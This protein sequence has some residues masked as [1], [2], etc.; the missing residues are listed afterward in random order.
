VIHVFVESNWI[1]DVCVPTFRRSP[2]AVA[3]LDHAAR[4]DVQIHIPH[5]C[6]REAKAV[7]LRKHQPKEHS[8]LQQ[9]RKW[10]KDQQ[11]IDESASATVNSF[12]QIFSNTVTT[13]LTRLDQ[14]LTEIE[15]ARGVDVFAL[16]EQM[17]ERSIELRTEVPDPPLKPF[18]EAILAAV[19]VR[20]T[21]LAPDARRA[22]CT[23]D[24]D[25]SP[26]VRGSVRKHLKAIYDAAQI[27]VRT[28]FD[29][30]GI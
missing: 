16:D 17:L 14:R 7:I 23:L 22:F 18:D 25:L 15:N 24:L 12:L 3:L 13:E 30:R 20:A 9:F 8:P 28:T 10:A 19:L 21:S 2:E 29:L 4:G 11:L 27:D 26:I 1:V 6:F 5:I